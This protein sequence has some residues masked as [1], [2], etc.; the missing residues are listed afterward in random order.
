LSGDPSVILGRPWELYLH[1]NFG[2]VSVELLSFTERDLRRWV[3]HVVDD[4]FDRE[5]LELAGLLVEPRPQGF[6]LVTLP[7]RGF[8][9]VLEGGDDDVR[10]D[11]LL[12][13]DG[14]DLLQQ[15]I[16]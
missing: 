14:V 12:L 16:D 7:G 4:L 3:G 5:Q 11:T 1:V 8:D 2:L 10:L 9:R 6:G 15:W 13:G